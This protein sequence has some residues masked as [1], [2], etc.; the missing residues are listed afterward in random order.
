MGMNDE[1]TRFHTAIVAN[2]MGRDDVGQELMDELA[3]VDKPGYPPAHFWIATRPDRQ[4]NAKDLQVLKHH[5]TTATDK[6]A[7][8]QIRIGA[9]LLLAKV[10]EMEKDYLKAADHYRAVAEAKPEVR[11]RSANLYALGGRSDMATI[12]LATAK[13]HFGEI[14]ESE[15]DNVE[16]RL[17]LATATFMLGAYDEAERILKESGDVRNNPR[18][19]YALAGIYATMATR[20]EAAGDDQFNLRLFFLQR[21]LDYHPR[22]PP[23]VRQVVELM[24]GDADDESSTVP[25]TLNNAM[26]DGRSTALVHLILATY[27]E[28]QQHAEKTRFHLEQAFSLN[29][30]MLRAFKN[31]AILLANAKPP[32]RQR[33]V[34][35]LT[36]AIDISPDPLIRE[37]R[38]QILTEMG[39]WERAL[40]DL[41]SAVPALPDNP[42]LLSKLAE[43]FDVLGKPKQAAKYRR[44]AK[45]AQ[46]ALS[47][48]GSA[49]E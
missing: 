40:P 5:L 7:A 39:Q 36:A 34:S 48:D 41:V 12:Q 30:Q 42:D 47:N 15:P 23:A 46:E 20:L 38:G 31:L 18:V 14:V 29:E 4:W 49:A 2:E 8:P 26:A 22:H 43:T 11:I 35:L 32:Q 28:I 21:A 33:A 25:A 3:P 10:F 24:P 9:F 45:E 1:E 13:R 44:R 37:A 17:Q 16:A 27:A 19:S 6:N